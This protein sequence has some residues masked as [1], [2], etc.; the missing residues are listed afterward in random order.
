M[1]I[2]ILLVY[3][4]MLTFILFYSFIQLHLTVSYRRNKKTKQR[5]KQ[6][7]NEAE[8]PMVTIQLPLYNEMYV[9]ERLLDCIAKFDYPTD[10]LEIQVLD[11]STDESFEIGAK[12]VQELAAQGLNIQHI[13][14]PNRIG[15]KAGALA[16]GMKFSKGE[17]IAI[18]DADFLPNPDFLKKTIPYFDTPKI[19]VVQ[20]KWEHLN[21]NF[22]LLTKLQAFGLDAHFSIEQRG[23]NASNHFINFNG[24]AGVWRT[25][26][27]LDAGGWQSD[28]I[29]EDL[30]LSYRAQL[31][32]WKFTYLENVGSPSELP[33]AM[34]ALKNQQFRWTKGAAECMRKNLGKVLVSKDLSWSTKINAVFH[35]MNSFLFICVFVLAILSVPM[36]FV[37]KAMPEYE[38][39]FKVASVFLTSLFILGFFYWTSYK[40]SKGGGILSFFKFIRTF[41]L[42]ISVSMGL[43]LHNAIAVIEGYIGRKTPFVRTPKFNIQTADQK[44]QKNK[45]LVSSLSWLT[46]IELLLVFYFAGGLYCAFWLEDFGLFPFHFMLFIGFSYVSF[47]SLKHSSYA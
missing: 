5:T 19:G 16:Y 12:K 17:F 43:S 11:D 4:S 30:D 6:A 28:T 39:I 24:T 26:C 42:F 14:R 22:S 21:E 46:I 1:A 10:K 25:S 38:T 13:K 2:A 34:N 3:G 32:G 31:K 9:V 35:L 44:W 20:T 41:F 7:L 40:S 37:K 15:Y 33:A 29:T 27:I 47:Y 45:Y 23:R 8:W 36:L 18:F